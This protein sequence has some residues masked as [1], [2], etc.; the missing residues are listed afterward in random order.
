VKAAVDEASSAIRV[1]GK[2]VREDFMRFAWI[3][4]VLVTGARQ[5]IG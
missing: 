2:R 3:N 1:A 5:L 4:D